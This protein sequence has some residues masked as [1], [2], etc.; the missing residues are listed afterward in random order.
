VWSILDSV[1][2]FPAS[3][4]SEEFEELIMVP[5]GGIEYMAGGTGFHTTIGQRA[6]VGKSKS[7]S[8]NKSA[9]EEEKQ[10]QPLTLTPR[11]A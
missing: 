5:R 10:P 11:C 3:L 4:G 7:K 6:L 2:G 1:N 8:K 9:G